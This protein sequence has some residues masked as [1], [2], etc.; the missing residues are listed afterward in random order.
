MNM[1]GLMAQAQKMQRDLKKAQE[2]L[3]KEEFTVSKSGAVTV[4]LFGNRK[5]KEIKI[6]KDALDVENKEMIEE[7]LALAIDEAQENI[8]QAESDIN[9]KIT[10][11]AGGFGGF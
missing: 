2:E 7:A 3:A 8:A 10:G 11:R 6:D 9:E 5:V 4:I 1:Q